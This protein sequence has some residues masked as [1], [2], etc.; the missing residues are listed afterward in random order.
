LS[1]VAAP[2]VAASMNRYC[3]SLS[4]LLHVLEECYTSASFSSSMT[5]VNTNTNTTNNNNT[6]NKH[7][8]EV[9]SSLLMYTFAEV[10]GGF[11]TKSTITQLQLDCSRRVLE[12]EK[13]PKVVI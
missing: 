1:I 8:S 3:N 13:P 4:F 2:E 7:N 6:N 9:A 11:P 12:D 10:Y 5:P